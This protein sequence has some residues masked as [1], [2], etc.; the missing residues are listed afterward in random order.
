M[1]LLYCKDK[2]AQAGRLI[3]AGVPR[4][5]VAIIYDVGLSTLYRKFPASK[6]V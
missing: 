4:Q 5:Q 3:G 2:G 6:R 1:F